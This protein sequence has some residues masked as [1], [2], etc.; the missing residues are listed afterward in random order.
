MEAVLE[1]IELGK[2]QSILAFEY[3]ADH[4][5]TP[6]HFH[7][8]HELTYIEESVGTKY[9]GD[10][11]G[12]YE[13]GELVLLRSNLPHCWKNHSDESKQSKS[14]VVH[15]NKGIYPK[16]PEL[17]PMFTMLTTASRG[18][19]FDKD[20]AASF[21]PRIKKLTELKNY[22][23]YIELLNLLSDLSDCNY[24]TLSEAH[25][26][27]DLPVEFGSR[28]SKIHDFIEKRFHEKIYLKELADLVS[29]SEQSFSRFFSKM[30][31]RPFF[32]F[33]NEYRINIASR[34]LIDTD[35]TIAQIGYACG[36]ESLPF[37]HKQFNKFK[38][39]SPLKFRKKYTIK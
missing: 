1:Q 33:L 21:L 5:D 11:V 24:K 36:Y 7:P 35:L 8:Q 25:F 31:G 10:Y 12:F 3:E 17:Q 13:P 34:M 4:F 37:F 14:I 23:L 22:K 28:M 18:V 39:S 30:M 15:W 32:T 16:V 19:V 2:K 38:Q 26:I 29:M 9:I 27:D 6:W 20:V